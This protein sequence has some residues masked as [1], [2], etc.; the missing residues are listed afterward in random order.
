LERHQ[1]SRGVALPTDLSHSPTATA[2]LGFAA[3]HLETIGWVSMIGGVIWALHLLLASHGVLHGDAIGHYII[4]REAWH[5]PTLLLHHWGRPL[6]TLVYLPSALFGL[7]YARLTSVLLGALTVLTAFQLAKRFGLGYAFAVPA[8]LWF[9]PW[10]ATWFVHP[11]MTEIPFSLMLTLSVF[12]IA[13]NRIALASVLIGLFPLVRMEALALTGL[14]VVICIWRREWRGAIVAAFPIVV[15]GVLYQIVFGQL[16]GGDFPLIPTSLFGPHPSAAGAEVH[17]W[18]LTRWLSYPI[19]LRH[20]AG[21]PITV[22][23]LFGIPWVFASRARLVGFAWYGAY[24]ALHVA[25]LLIGQV[26]NPEDRYLLPLAPAIGIAGAAGLEALVRPI[27]LWLERRP[28][29]RAVSVAWANSIAALVIVGV[30]ANGLRVSPVPRGPWKSVAKN[31]TTWLRQERLVDR[32]IVSTD[33]YVY[34]YLPGHFMPPHPG[35]DPEALWNS[36]PPL[37]ALPSG[38]IAVWDSE[39]SD[40]GYGLTYSA[41]SSKP[42]EWRLSKGFEVGDQRIVI[43]RKERP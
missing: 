35:G 33:V 24:A 14:W 19:I 27:R 20:G 8:L 10:F 42:Q 1:S 12:L 28:D 29:M 2:P 5:R 30:V 9:Q 22:L 38:S 37:S 16:P 31:A 13:S 26:Q 36:P 39:F 41:L 23:A 4:S 32:T 11:S 40:H 3:G 6:S 25:L 21:L 15:Y 18:R 34:Y 17:P 7:K 43:F